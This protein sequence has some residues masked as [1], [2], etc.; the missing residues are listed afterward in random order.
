MHRWRAADIVGIDIVTAVVVD[1]TV[2]VAVAVAVG[3][4]GAVGAV[5]D[6]VVTAITAV[7]VDD[8]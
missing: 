1:H 3:A 8:Y 5:V 4:V 6:V 2:A 7:A